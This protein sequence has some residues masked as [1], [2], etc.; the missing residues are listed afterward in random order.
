MPLPLDQQEVLLR[1]PALIIGATIKSDGTGFFSSFR[2]AN[3]GAQFLDNAVTLY[4]D[5][6]LVLELLAVMDAEHELPG[7]LDEITADVVYTQIEHVK[8]LIGGSPY[9]PGFYEFIYN[10]A[11]AVANASGG[12]LFGSGDKITRGEADFLED[13]RTQLGIV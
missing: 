1:L 8:A 12:G 11:V 13:L 2:E 10:L 9:A 7:D 5:N 3:A 6:V 4:K